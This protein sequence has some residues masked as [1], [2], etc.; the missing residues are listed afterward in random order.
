[1]LKKLLLVIALLAFATPALAARPFQP[2]V[3]QQYVAPVVE[4]V[5]PVA[6]SGVSYLNFVQG[7]ATQ[8]V[9]ANQYVSWL[10]KQ[11]GH[12]YIVWSFVSR[13]YPLNEYSAPWDGNRLL[14]EY[15]ASNN[16]GYSNIYDFSER[17]FLSTAQRVWLPYA[18]IFLRVV[19]VTNGQYSLSRELHI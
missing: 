10:T 3:L 11:F 5:T 14:T 13:N 12:S 15:N 17:S 9:Y 16:F 2:I 4:E 7:F 8:P 1:M 6:H 18:G 19:T